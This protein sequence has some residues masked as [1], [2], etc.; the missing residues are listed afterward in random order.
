VDR[1]MQITYNNPKLEAHGVVKF[2]ILTDRLDRTFLFEY[3]RRKITERSDVLSALAQRNACGNRSTPAVEW[4]FSK[5]VQGWEAWNQ[6]SEPTVRDGA[7]TMQ[8]QGTDPYMGGPPFNVLAI[9]VSNVEITLRA[10]GDT[11]TMHG[12]VYWLA[13]DQPDFLPNLNAPFAVQADGE[14]HTYRIDIGGTGQLFVGDHITQL[15]LDPV[16]APAD[17]AI[18]T[19]RVNVR[20][21][22]PQE[23]LCSCSP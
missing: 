16:D 1:A 11:P 17:I 18:K 8:A 23:N 2:P 12:A 4:D 3:N 10:R 6:L 14:F 5:G 21:V 13:T 20:C 22:T 9:A 15:R 19:I 7:L